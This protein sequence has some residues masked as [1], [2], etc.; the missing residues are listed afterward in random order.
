MPGC[1]GV[2]HDRPRHDPTGDGPGAIRP[3]PHQQAT[4]VG[5]ASLVRVS[6]EAGLSANTGNGVLRHLG[7]LAA[8]GPVER[9]NVSRIGRIYY[10]YRIAPGLTFVPAAAIPC[11]GGTTR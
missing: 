11:P 8:A 1:S 10:R 9:V 4:G 7:I 5:F 6:S 2:P 3:R